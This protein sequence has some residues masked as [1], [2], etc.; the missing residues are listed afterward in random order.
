MKPA[1]FYIPRNIDLSKFPEEEQQYIAFFLN[2]LHWKWICWRADENGLIRLKHEYITEIIPRKQWLNIRD[3]L[4]GLG[5][6]R[7]CQSWTPGSFSKGY[8]LAPEFRDTH[9][10]ECTDDKLNKKIIRLRKK[11]TCLP[12]HHYL[13]SWIKRLCFDNKHA[14]RLLPRIRSKNSKIPESEFQ[15]LLREMCRVIANGDA[16]N[17]TVDH[18][19]RV[20]TF[21]TRLPKELRQCL[22][23]AG[24][25]LVN[26]DLVNSQP[27]IAGMIAT[28]YF[29]DPSSGYRL[30]NRKFIAGENPYHKRRPHPAK[31][32]L[33]DLQK[34]LAICE[35]GRIYE[36]LMRKSDSRNKIKIDFLTMMF[37]KNRCKIPLKK[38]FG[39]IYPSV[40]KMLQHLKKKDYRH[41]AHL[42]QNY[43]STIFIHLICRR[44]MEDHPS[45]PIFTIHDSILT[46]PEYVQVVTRVIKDAFGELGINPKLGE[47][48]YERRPDII[49]PQFGER[50]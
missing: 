40:A 18:Y 13:E 26:I 33:E 12:V 38:R 16:Q 35:S 46:T 50:R 49:T 48:S 24:Q 44:L 10:I 17:V 36:S 4:W 21:I 32:N 31:T 27:L 47:E 45:I 22:S 34:Y 9:R 5:I 30:R 19:G 3:R 6:I 29:R 8:R 20:H 14:A 7:C 37:S 42:M 25:H 15:F 39:T 28:S 2:L 43:E 1:A 23:V 41:A 11:R